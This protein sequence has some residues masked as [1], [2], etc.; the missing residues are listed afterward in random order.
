[1]DQTSETSRGGHTRIG[2][3]GGTFDPVHYAHLAIAEE[4][5]QA[6]QLAKMVFVPAGEP[7]HKVGY[8]I[9]PVEHRVAMLERAIAS[10]PHFALSL[11]DVRRSGPSYTVETLRLLRREWGERTD[12][13]FVLGGDSLKDLPTWYNAPGVLAQAVIVA[14]VRPGYADL[15]T[16]RERLATSLPGIRDRLIT[17]EGP[18]MEISSTDLRR[19]VAQGRPIKYQVPEAVEEYI[20]RHGLYRDE[21]SGQVVEDTREDT[22]ATNAI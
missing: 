7:P 20:F 10:N 19:R 15:T 2:V 11:V 18:R 4:V 16:S 6:L 3:I 5:Y 22:H 17:L 1:M 21:V 12:L 9:T 8:Q 13:Y 14:L